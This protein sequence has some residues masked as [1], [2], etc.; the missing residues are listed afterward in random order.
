M[1]SANVLGN[2]RSC[3]ETNSHSQVAQA[4]LRKHRKIM[5]IIKG[6]FQN[7][8]L[9][10]M[11]AGLHAATMSFAADAGAGGGASSSHRPG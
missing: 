8:K 4:G 6:P 3:R 2:T 1:G 5:Q 7:E 11:E 9:W 10:R